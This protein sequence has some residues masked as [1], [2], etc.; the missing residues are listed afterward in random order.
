M[1]TTPD[2]IASGF[3][4][5]AHWSQLARMAQGDQLQ[6]L[7]EFV[8]RYPDPNAVG[9]DFV[10]NLLAVSRTY[11]RGVVKAGG[12]LPDGLTEW[13]Q[14]ALDRYERELP[15]NTWRRLARSDELPTMAEL[16]AAQK[17]GG[18]EYQALVDKVRAIGRFFSDS[19][20]IGLINISDYASDLPGGNLFEKY[21]KHDREISSLQK[22]VKE[23]HDF[24]G[25]ADWR[26][27]QYL[28][29]LQTLSQTIA[30]RLESDVEAGH[31]R[32]GAQAYGEGYGGDVGASR[33][34]GKTP[35]SIAIRV[36]R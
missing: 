21:L 3:L 1:G 10:P 8:G 5:V 20:I 23:A 25:Q 9:S 17:R 19:I 6:K 16:K 31:Q 28:I 34:S 18:E 33:T 15:V 13:R 29:D 12:T 35:P 4:T 2:A 26:E 7:T 36:Q 30:A 27:L 22:R 11:M 24:V 14:A 32:A